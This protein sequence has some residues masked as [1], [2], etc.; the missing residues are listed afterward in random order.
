MTFRNEHMVM[1]LRTY[2][3]A[4]ADPE[5]DREEDG[6]VGEYTDWDVGD[7]ETGA[8]DDDAEGDNWEYEG[9]EDDIEDTG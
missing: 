5:G 1:T 9:A 2:D 4:D 8:D 6:G 7:I 3:E